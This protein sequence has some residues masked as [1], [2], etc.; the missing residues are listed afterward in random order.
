MIINS[1]IGRLPF[2][3]SRLEVRRGTLR[4]EGAM[5][6]WPTSVEVPLAEMPRIA[7]Q[8]L[9]GRGIAIGVGTLAAAATGL[10][11]AR[12]RGR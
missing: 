12:R 7:R 5:G 9:P 4:L 11:L 2:T 1:P 3:A 6:T 8:L 10:R